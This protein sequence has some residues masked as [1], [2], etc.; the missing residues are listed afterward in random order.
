MKVL[1]PEDL[2][3]LKVQ[4][5]AN[6]PSRKNA[7]LADIELLMKHHGAALDWSLL[8]TYFELFGSGDIFNELRRQYGGI[9]QQ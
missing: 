3:G 7:D 5:T 6:D 4:A 9:K 1:R 8:Q 2:I